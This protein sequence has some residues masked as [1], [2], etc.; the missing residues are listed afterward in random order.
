M[1]NWNSLEHSVWKNL[2]SCG[3]QD[4]SKFLICVSGGLDSMAL[5]EIILNLKPQADFKVAYF[6]HGPAEA[7]QMK[8]RNE[9]RNLILEKVQ[10]A[11][12]DDINSGR[13]RKIQFLTSESP[14]ELKSEDR[15][16]AARWEFINQNCEENEVVVTAHHL[17]DRFETVLLKMLRGSS[18]EGISSFKM[19]NTL[20]FRPLLNLNKEQLLLY[21]QSR[22][23]KWAEDPSNKDSSYLRN[24]LR[25][26]WLVELE[27]RYPGS[28]SNFAK[29]M[30]KIL[31]DSV[32]TQTFE[33]QFAE[34]SVQN[35]LKRTWFLLLSDHDQARALALF[36]KRHN[37]YEF[38]GGHLDEIRKR[39]DKNQ[40]DITFEML[41]RKWVI[42]ASQIMLDLV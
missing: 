26:T 5:L 10:A 3:L 14:S 30:F 19:W 36:L 37:I 35:S 31:E 4:Q 11:T 13:Q 22:G 32:A 8:F 1:Q 12:F 39:L 18:L 15:M 6:H 24:W 33:Q 23:V 16:R 42:N 41:G 9:C 40:K 20:I 2:T 7:E 25:E 21:A 29:S 38:T 27:N 34:N 28:K 17:D